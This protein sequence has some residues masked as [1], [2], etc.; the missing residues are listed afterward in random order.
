MIINISTFRAQ[1]DVICDYIPLVSSATNL[2]DLFQKAVI[3]PRMSPNEIKQDRYYSVLNNKPFWRCLCLL[4]IPGL[5][6]LVF[7]IKDYWGPKRS[8]LIAVKQ[9]GMELRYVSNELKKDRE[10]VLAAVKE[11]GLALEYA[12]DELKNDREV[13]LA[14]VEE[15]GWAIEYASDELK[16]DREV[17]LAAVKKNGWTI[18]YANE[19]LKND[20]EI[21]LVFEND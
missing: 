9:D 13:V 3:I 18:G 5:S 7:A 20:Q 8:A 6:N 17:V 19:E 4:M 1:T 15:N 11:N 10:V 16:N 12:S 14:A 21:L 2:I